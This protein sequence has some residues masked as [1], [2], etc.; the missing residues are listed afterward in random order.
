[1]LQG[2]PVDRRLVAKRRLSRRADKLLSDLTPQYLVIG[3]GA[4]QLLLVIATGNNPL[5][6]LDPMENNNNRTLKEL[7]TPDVLY[8]PWCIQYP[9]LEPA[10]TYELKSKLIHLLPKFHGLVGEDPHKH[11]K[12]FHVV[13]STMRPQG[14]SE[15][16]IK[17]KAFPFSLDGVAKDWLYLQLWPYERRSVESSNIQGKHYMSIKKDLISC[18]PHVHTTK[19]AN[20]CCYRSLMMDQNMI[21]AASREAL[22]DKTPVATRHL[23][24]N[25]ARGANTSR[26]V[27]EVNTFDNLRLENQL[28][29]LTSL[30]RQLAVGQHQQV[31]Q[32]EDELENIESMGVLGG[33]HQF[34]RQLYPN[35]QFDNQQFWRQPYQLV[36]NHANYQQQGLRYQALAFCQQPQQLLPP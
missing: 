2:V 20:N 29:K 22:M 30:V 11:L 7:A 27:S 34:G 18:A 10:Q 33:E 31:A 26:A 12:E 23:I 32:R 4:Q 8:Q 13:C 9:H 3:G 28:T 24:S 1:M 17:M 5:F 21:D 15:D 16:Y 19:S 6:E 35:R 25:M 14:I 36:S